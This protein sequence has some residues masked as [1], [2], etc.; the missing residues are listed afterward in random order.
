MSAKQVLD[1]DPLAQQAAVIAQLQILAQTLASLPSTT[2]TPPPQLSHYRS[3]PKAVSQAYHTMEQGAVLVSATATKYTL[4]GKLNV[5]EQSKMSADLL[6]GCQHIATSC[7]ALHCDKPPKGGN[8]D[9]DAG[10]DDVDGMGCSRSARQ[11]ARQA[12]RAI[13]TT[14][15][16]L[17]EAFVQGEAVETDHPNL[18][19]QKTGAVWEACQNVTEKKM[20][21]GNRNAMR[22]DLLTYRLECHETW[23][24]FQAMVVAAEAA[25][26]ENVN[27]E[28]EPPQDEDQWEAFLNGQ[29][30]QYSVAELPVAASCVSIFK[31]SRGSINLALQAIE[32][33]GEQLSSNNNNNNDVDKAQLSWI[34][35]LHD[36]ASAVGCGVTDLGATLYPPLDYESV[37]VQAERQFKA[38]SAVVQYILDA[39]TTTTTTCSFDLPS[40]ITELASKLQ[41]AI[42]T[43]QSEASQAGHG[44]G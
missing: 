3:I 31:I 44:S 12:A 35:A 32:A 39:T 5:E 24:E 36:L 28:E 41:T 2:A 4:M 19:A 11:H 1:H 6:Q 10:G 25:Q 29:Q 18:G 8:D 16:Q 9:D 42:A 33:V 27:L 30:D 17:M 15:I 37:Y 43:R 23:Q 38:V 14:V 20:P 40:D 21:R 26:P 22:R 7:L 13:L 34:S